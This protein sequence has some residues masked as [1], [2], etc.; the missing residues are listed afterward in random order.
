MRAMLLCALAASALLIGTGSSLAQDRRE[1]LSV[2]DV[3]GRHHQLDGRTIEVRGW[4]SNC[5]R[6]SYR[7]M[8]G[9]G[10]AGT[11]YL[12]IGGSRS[13][14]ARIH[15][16]AGQRITIRA[17]LDARCMHARADSS[18]EGDEVV[19]CTDR[20]SELRN[21]VLVERHH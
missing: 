15:G 21:P 7:L 4:L 20:A 9:I 5:Q 17:R 2:E 16:R 11:P 13:F 1:P 3:I 12:S 8:A 6:L 10:G 18:R 19:I 14:D